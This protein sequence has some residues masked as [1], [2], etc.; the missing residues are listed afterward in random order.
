VIF[1][2]RSVVQTVHLTR[3]PTYHAWEL[4]R[5]LVE[6]GLA[7]VNSSATEEVLGRWSA[8][9]FS[10]GGLHASIDEATTLPGRHPRYVA[11]PQWLVAVVDDYKGA[12][13]LVAFSVELLTSVAAAECLGGED[14]ACDVIRAAGLAPGWAE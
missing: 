12:D 14:A 2:I 6:V 4:V 3:L 5:R 7:E 9:R 8:R 10:V 13:V 1:P 11:L